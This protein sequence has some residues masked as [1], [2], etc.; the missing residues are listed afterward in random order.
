[1]KSE[2]LEAE[3]ARESG[4]GSGKQ[5]GGQCRGH[6]RMCWATRGPQSAA[7]PA[8][9]QA[10]ADVGGPGGHTGESGAGET[11]T[12]C[13]TCTP[14]PRPR[15][16][17]PTPCSA[18]LPPSPAPQKP[19]AASN[20]PV[21]L[22][23]AGNRLAGHRR[24]SPRSPDCPP[25]LTSAQPL[26]AGPGPPPGPRCAPALTSAAGPQ[27]SPAGPAAAEEGAHVAGRS[28]PSRH[29]SFGTSPPRCRRGSSGAPRRAGAGWSGGL[30]GTRCPWAK[31]ARPAEGVTSRVWVA[32]PGAVQPVA[33]QA[34]GHPT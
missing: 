17:A 20:R 11:L 8:R 32:R 15:R 31:G 4:P 24:L 22:R 3:G 1:M 21:Q 14:C 5:D 10:S 34:W 33:E 6:P 26:P 28:Q 30:T 13:G 7:V 23:V 29:G 27:W 2:R 18:L 16:A 12:A 25:G 19:A 9:A